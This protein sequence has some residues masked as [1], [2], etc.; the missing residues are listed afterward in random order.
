MKLAPVEIEARRGAVGTSAVVL[1]V[2][3][4]RAPAAAVGVIW[5]LLFAVT[6]VVLTW[7]VPPDALVEQANAPAEAEEQVATEG[8]AAVPDPAQFVAV[9]YLAPETD[10]GFALTFPLVEIFPVA[11]MDIT[12][13][14]PLL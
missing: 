5:M 3:L 4:R 8:F 2:T 6:A 14:P 13:E 7:Q 9:P 12:A 1:Q 10:P 11:P